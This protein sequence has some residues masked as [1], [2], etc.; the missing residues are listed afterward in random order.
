MK[1]EEGFTNMT[2][3]AT[4]TQRERLRVS[5]DVDKAD[6]EEARRIMTKLTKAE[7]PGIALPLTDEQVAFSLYLNGIDAYFESYGEDEETRA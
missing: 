1:A 4:E 3:A 5:F 6:F 7:D 2:T